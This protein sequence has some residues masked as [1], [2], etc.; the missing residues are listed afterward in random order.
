M[1]L[2]FHLRPDMRDLSV[3]VDQIGD[4]MNAEKGLPVHA[5]FA[6][7]AIGLEHLVGFVREQREGK[8]IFVAKLALRFHGVGG[9]AENHSPGLLELFSQSIERDRKSTRLNS[10][11]A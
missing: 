6:P 11:H 9:D 4:P 3:P 1:S 10:S 5:L 2:D 8:A 7:G